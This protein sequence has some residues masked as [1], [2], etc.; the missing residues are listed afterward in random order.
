MA[1]PIGETESGVV[2]LDFDRRLKLEFHGSKVTSDAKG[3][4]IGPNW[5]TT[6]ALSAEMRLI[7]QRREAWLANPACSAIIRPHSRSYLGNVG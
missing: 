6:G 5:A 2:R 7:G 4:G 1:H 3:G